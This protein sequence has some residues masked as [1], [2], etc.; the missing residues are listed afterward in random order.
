VVPDFDSTTD[1]TPVVLRPSSGGMAM[2]DG[3]TPGSYHV[4]TFRSP[5]QLEYR[6]PEAMAALSNHAQ[7]VT[8]DPGVSASL[9]VQVPEH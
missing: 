3:L 6:N 8:V 9:V 5:V 7:I 1:I 4:Y 2:L